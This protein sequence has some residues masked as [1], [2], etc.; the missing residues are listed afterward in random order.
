MAEA[1]KHFF[2]RSLV[3]RLARSLADAWPAFPT[4]AFV[5]DA[6]RDLDELELLDRARHIT[7]ALHAHLPASYPEALRVLLA[8]LGP[9]HASDELEGAGM[10]PFFYLPHTM[11]VAEHGLAHFEL[12]MN[13]QHALTRRFTCEF[14]IRPF[15]E[16]APDETL[17]VLH[18][19]TRDPSP[20][21]RRLVSEGTRPR[22]PWAPRVSWIEKHPERVLPLLEALRDDPA[23][24]VRRSV[25]NH[26][27]DLSKTDPD[28]VAQI[29][30]RWLADA[31]PERRALVKHALRSAVKR[32]HR[33]SLEVLGFGGA[34]VVSIEDI[35]ITPR[36]VK[37]GERVC[38]EL[39]LRSRAKRAQTLAVDLVVHFVKVRGTGAKVFKLKTV[40]LAPRAAVTLAKTVSLAV[41]TTRSPNAGEH[42]VEALVNGVAHPLGTFTVLKT[43]IASPSS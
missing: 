36:R 31:S 12:S 11:F 21:V 32:G 24:V 33:A 14:S 20:H 37:I 34:P 29:A 1:L 10:A 39:A 16:H 4:K 6:T 40:E 35:R 15:L 22:L 41:H 18:G 27:N 8:S 5:R 38:V 19:W 17:A 30:R 26:L 9:E 7:R 43:S 2:S 28:R 42:R 13:A 3:V 23:S 25:A